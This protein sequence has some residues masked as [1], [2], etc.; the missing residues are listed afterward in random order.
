VFFAAG[1]GNESVDNDGYASYAKVIAVA[2]CNDHNSRSVYSDFGDAVWCAFPSSDFGHPPFNHPDPL[3]SG[4]WTTDRVGRDGY[5]T[6]QITG[7]DMGGNYTNDFGGTSSACPGAAGVAALVLSVNPELKW[8]E[9]K[10]LLKRACDRIDP[11]G[12]NYDTTGHSPKYGYGRLN[13]RTAVELAAPQPQSG[14]TVKR[15]F[16]APIPDLQTVSF[17]LD[18]ADSTPVESLSVDVDLKHTYIS[19][20]IISL[21]PPAGT[22]VSQVI[23]HNRAGGSGNDLKKRYD[24]ATT[25]ALARFGGKSCKG[26]WR[27]QIRD[28]AAEDFGS[29]VSFALNLMFAHPD[30]AVRRPEPKRIKKRSKK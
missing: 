30:R 24:P 28:V 26:T 14:I 18:V 3:T 12:G 15:T 6:G 19:D 21:H 27:L 2:A 13:A 7:G 9:V 17:T 29:L 16:D 11:Q 1:N 20:L 10:D 22:G 8:H 23:L 4:I 25:P 5:N